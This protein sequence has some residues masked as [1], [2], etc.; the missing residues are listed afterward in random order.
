LIQKAHAVVGLGLLSLEHTLFR[1][2]TENINV[3]YST[4]TGKF[5]F[6]LCPFA[7]VFL[8]EYDSR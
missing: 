7:L 8:P 6:D 4:E 3:T 5:I 1:N 2:H